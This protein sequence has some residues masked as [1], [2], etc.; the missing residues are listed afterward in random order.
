MLESMLKRTQDV[1]KFFL[2]DARWIERKSLA[3]QTV[4][5]KSFDGEQA[6]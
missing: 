5:D 6:M 4:D 2:C 1:N 3:F